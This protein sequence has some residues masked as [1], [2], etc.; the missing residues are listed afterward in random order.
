MVLDFQTA[1]RERMEE[2]PVRFLARD[3]EP[4][5]DAARRDVA[6]FVGAATR[7]LVFVRNATEAVNAVVRSLA[8]KRG[9]ELLVTDHGYNACTNALRFR[10]TE[11]GA[12]VVTAKVPFPCSSPEAI[13]DAILSSVTR[14]TRL[15]L[16]DHIT[17]PTA[18]VFPIAKIVRE[19]EARGVMTL[20]DGAH[21]P[22]SVPLDVRAIGAAF[23]TGNLH[24]WVCAPK[25]AAFL[26][27]RHDLQR[28]VRPSVIS[29]GAND[30]RKNRAR[31]FA[32]F[33]WT[34]TADPTAI[35]SAPFAINQVPQLAGLRSWSEVMTRNR[36]LVL[37]GRDIVANALLR[38]EV[39]ANPA[40]QKRWRGLAAMPLDL[41]ASMAALPL[42]ARKGVAPK[43]PLHM[44]P[45]Q[46]A[47]LDQHRIEVPIPT[48]P[49]HPNRVIRISA[50]I[51]NSIADYESLADAV[52]WRLADRSP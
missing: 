30:P 2:N 35:L 18:L 15:A 38:A 41:I 12:R 31:M 45:L 6:R 17:S 49:R 51:Y 3:L 7:D 48:W 37:Q 11:T 43:S 22:G 44:D 39:G 9:D 40:S 14:R 36:S 25:G 10:A 50:H 34:G 23:Y 42:P 21:A 4:A 19:L 16:I 33:D 13:T 47:L 46:D 1:L 8:F 5:L 32:E 29:H 52:R 26:A 20:V 24:K 27:V 28:T